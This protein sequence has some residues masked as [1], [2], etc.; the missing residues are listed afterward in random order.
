MAL[1]TMRSSPYNDSQS[2]TKR[3]Q[4]RCMI[5]MDS[6][7]RTATYNFEHPCAHARV[8]AHALAHAQL[9]LLTTWLAKDL[10]ALSCVLS[11]EMENM[12][13][14]EPCKLVCVE[15]LRVNTQ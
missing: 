1:T 4:A 14:S 12:Q 5:T 3:V 10:I 2:G 15:G 7:S 13:S 11:Y 9:P 8:H 6:L